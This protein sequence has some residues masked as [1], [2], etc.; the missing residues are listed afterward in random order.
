M[1]TITALCS[2]LLS[3]FPLTA[4]AEGALSAHV[5]NPESIRSFEHRGNMVSVSAD[6]PK[7]VYGT[8]RLELSGQGAHVSR[9]I[10]L[11]EDGTGSYHNY[12]N[13]EAPQSFEWGVLVS[14]G[15][16]EITRP[17]N[18]YWVMEPLNEDVYS[19]R[20]YLIVMKSV[21]GKYSHSLIIKKDSVM[22]M[23]GPMGMAVYK[24]IED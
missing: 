6:L 17:T 12:G 19:D 10:T 2:V 3:L 20:A 15:I 5:V 7:E 8:Y 22:V 23:P 13:K 18:K 21:E 14:D 9:T 16:T 4:F 1:K 11:N 24:V